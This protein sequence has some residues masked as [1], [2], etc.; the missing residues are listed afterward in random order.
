MPIG[1][2]RQ[3]LQHQPVRVPID[4]QR[5]QAVGLAVHQPIRRGVDPER[6][7]ERRGR[8]NPV[9]PAML[10]EVRVA[11]ADHPQGD[12]RLV[13]EERVAQRAAIGRDH[14]H[15]IAGLGVD[16]GDVAAID[17]RMTGPNPIFAAPGD[18]Y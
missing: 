12:L 2:L 10:A 1:G 7:A 16:R 4:D 3:R 5:R 6:V 15:D 18:D 17:P 13:A 9:A 8:A 11:L 14:A